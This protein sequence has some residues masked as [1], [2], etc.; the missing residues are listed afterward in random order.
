MSRFTRCAALSCAPTVNEIVSGATPSA[1]HHSM[2]AGYLLHMSRGPAAVRALIVSDLR[3]FLDLGVR[4]RV[5]DLLIVLRFF[6]ALHPEA[7]RAPN[8]SSR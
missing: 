8:A 7:A 1:R 4:S 2:L 3:G 5:A 6:L